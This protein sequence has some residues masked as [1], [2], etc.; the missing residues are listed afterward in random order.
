MSSSL[1][2]PLRSAAPPRTVAE[3]VREP[4]DQ[5]SASNLDALS[6]AE[7]PT[8]PLASQGKHLVRK[9]LVTACLTTTG[10]A[11]MMAGIPTAAAAQLQ[12]RGLV[13]SKDPA[14]R[15][16]VASSLV[17]GRI[18]AGT[19]EE[20]LARLK[21]EV[22]SLLSGLPQDTQKSYVD[23]DSGARRWVAGRVDGQTETVFGNVKNRKAFVSGHFFVINIF[24]QL[25]DQIAGEVR[26]GTIPREAQPRINAAIDGLNKLKPAQREILARALEAEFK[27]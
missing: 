21:P 24:G 6:A 10:V 20:R 2:S 18:P 22:R 4:Q 3:E 15:Q 13:P 26:K 25:K 12:N 14:V 27:A 5:F 23:L 9:A 17:T 16:L 7:A 11:G 8:A 19:V 1:S